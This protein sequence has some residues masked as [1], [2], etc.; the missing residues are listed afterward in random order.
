MGN[1]TQKTFGYLKTLKD[2]NMNSYSVTV[3]LRQ[4]HSFDLDEMLKN[5]KI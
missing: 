3:W 5:E 4:V 2:L 1:R